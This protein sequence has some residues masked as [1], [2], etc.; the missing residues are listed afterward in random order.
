MAAE[1][2]ERQRQPEIVSEVLDAKLTKEVE[3]ILEEAEQSQAESQSETGHWY[4]R[5]PCAGVRYYSFEA[6]KPS[7]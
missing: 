1:V 4:Y 6:G 3:A 7:L 2:L 5:V